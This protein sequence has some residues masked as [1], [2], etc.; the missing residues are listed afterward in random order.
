MIVSSIDPAGDIEVSNSTWIST[1]CIL[2]RDFDKIK[3]VDEVNRYFNLHTIDIFFGGNEKPV[4]GRC[5]I[6][7]CCRLRFTTEGRLTFPT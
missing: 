1:E 3:L 2:K 5:I 4:P 7:V 6:S